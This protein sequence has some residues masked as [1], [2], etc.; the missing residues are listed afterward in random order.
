[1]IIGYLDPLGVG[2][3]CS[4]RPSAHLD[5]PCTLVEALSLYLIRDPNRA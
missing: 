4:Y 5:S 2:I 3:P 1:M